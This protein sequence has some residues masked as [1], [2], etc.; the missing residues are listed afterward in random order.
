MLLIAGAVAAC[1]TRARSFQISEPNGS[2][3]AN[4][5]SISTETI[6]EP[7]VHFEP[8]SPAPPQAGTQDQ[9]R[10]CTKCNT[11]YFNGYR[12]R[13]RCPA[14]GAHSGAPLTNFILAYDDS[15]GGAGQ[16]DWR[17]CTKCKAL[18]F[19]GYAQK[20]VC[21]GG[22]G[23]AAAGYNFRMRHSVRAGSYD[24]PFRY[25]NN[26]HVLF[27]TG[28]GGAS[29]CSARGA[30]VAAGYQFVVKFKGGGFQ[31]DTEQIPARH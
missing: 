4:Q 31:G 10:R 1:Q 20:G 5:E 21:A 6:A 18:F 14:G 26:C 2:E 3:T 15:P 28:R 29:V 16:R 7:H 30:H 13:G 9:W 19:D 27:F 12:D 8:I 22:G 24:D 11:L 25:C 17:Y 23:H